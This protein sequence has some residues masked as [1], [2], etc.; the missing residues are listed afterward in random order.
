MRRINAVFG[1]STNRSVQNNRAGFTLIELVVTIVVFLVVCTA[2][3]VNWVSFIQYQDMRRAALGLH[4]ELISLKAKALED[5][6]TY[7]IKYAGP[8]FYEVWNE[9]TV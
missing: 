7:E 5:S 1:I 2:A 8:N 9:D 6:I 3:I 4:K